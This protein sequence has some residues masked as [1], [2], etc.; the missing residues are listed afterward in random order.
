MRLA[1]SLFCRNFYQNMHY[2]RFIIKVTNL[3]HVAVSKYRIIRNHSMPC[4][5]PKLY[6]YIYLYLDIYHCC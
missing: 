4:I 2:N 3:L 5:L 1:I 6:G